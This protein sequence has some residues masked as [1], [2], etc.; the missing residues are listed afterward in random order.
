MYVDIYHAAVTGSCSRWLQCK[1]YLRCVQRLADCVLQVKDIL[2]ASGLEVDV[3]SNKALAAW[4]EAACA[5]APEA[6][7]LIKA[8]TVRAMSEAQY[9]S[10]GLAYTTLTAHLLSGASLS[11]GSPHCAL[12]SKLLVVFHVVDLNDTFLAYGEYGDYTVGPHSPYAPNVSSKG[13]Q[14]L[15]LAN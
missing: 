12:S 9:C 5:A 8:L 6:A 2:D 7:S 10:T 1:L 3:T 4:L 13:H 11:E 14:W 15:N